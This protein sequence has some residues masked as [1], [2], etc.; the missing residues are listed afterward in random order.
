[1]RCQSLPPYS[2]HISTAH[3]DPASGDLFNFGL[4][5]AMGACVGGQG[6]GMGVYV[7]S[8]RV[9]GRLWNIVEE[10]S[11]A[12]DHDFQD[13]RSTSIASLQGMQLK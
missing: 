4:R 9:V 8:I 7:D 12:A 2:L 13:S 3:D 1:M 5:A 11:L 6:E 10:V